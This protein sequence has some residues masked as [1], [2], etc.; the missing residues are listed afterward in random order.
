LAG[1]QT[2]LGIVRYNTPG[3]EG[4][5]IAA[6]TRLQSLYRPVLGPAVSARHLWFAH[7]A[8]G[9]VVVSPT[10]ESGEF[11]SRFIWGRAMDEY[12]IASDKSVLAALKAPASDA[13]SLTGVFVLGSAQPD[14]VRLVTSPSLVHTLKRVSGDNA[15]AWATRGWAAHVLANRRPTLNID[16]VAEFVLL[17]FNTGSDE[18]LADTVTLPDAHVVEVDQWA[19][20]EWTYWPLAERVAGGEATTARVLRSALCER[21]IPLKSNP[22]VRLGLTAG[23]D[24]TLIASCAAEVRVNLDTFTIGRRWGRDVAA[25]RGAARAVG[26]SH[27]A[28]QPE[29]GEPTWQRMTALSIWTEGLRPGSAL[30]E[31]TLRWRATGIDR[32]TGH[33]AEIGRAFYAKPTDNREWLSKFT[34]VV[35]DRLPP[36]I[37]NHTVERLYSTFTALGELGRPPEDLPALLYATGR[38]AKWL[39]RELP[40]AQ[41]ANTV[42]FYLAPD[43]VRHLLNVPL[44]DRNTGTVFAEAQDLARINVFARAS[45]AADRRTPLRKLGPLPA[46]RSTAQRLAQAL[47]TL[48]HERVTSELLGDEFVRTTLRRASTQAWARQHAWNLLAVEALAAGLSQHANAAALVWF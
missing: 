46:G 20:R 22:A 3:A 4:R 16:A 18:L 32:L 47:A 7:L 9:I 26:F 2:V 21:L 1:D 36:H 30:L 37:A 17:G 48:P 34:A 6:V 44:D 12:G 27:R 35:K 39:C 31:R 14:H 24:S 8:T 25:A 11:A 38:M 40:I 13:R 10:S 5:F 41:F 29:Y 45:R 42:P 28:I 33:G 23:Q 15:T 19:S 43:L